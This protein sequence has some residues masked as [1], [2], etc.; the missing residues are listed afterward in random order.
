[1]SEDWFLDSV[2][3]LVDFARSITELVSFWASSRMIS[4]A[5]YPSFIASECPI[6]VLTR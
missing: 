6:K 3:K 5:L 2:L 1:M 4:E